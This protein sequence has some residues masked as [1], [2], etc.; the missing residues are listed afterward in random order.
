LISV[1]E[2]TSEIGLRKAIGARK[3]DIVLLFLSESI[4]ISGFGSLIGL[5]FGVLMTFLVIPIVRYYAEV[6][7]FQAEYTL[8]TLFIIAI[9]AVLIGVVFGTYPALRAS[10]LS[11]IDA[12][13]RE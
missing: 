7:F 13:R 4:S 6:P 5:I 10:K 2:R 8:N 9:V 12:I 1:S 11:P 3:M